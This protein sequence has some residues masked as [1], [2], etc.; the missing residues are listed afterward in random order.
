M[1]TITEL[2]LDAL[3]Y[4]HLRD[5][6]AIDSEDDM[7]EFAKLACFTGKD[8]DDAI[9]ADINKRMYLENLKTNL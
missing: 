4:Q 8:F 7:G 2:A 1:K 6:F 3:R 9:D 5:F